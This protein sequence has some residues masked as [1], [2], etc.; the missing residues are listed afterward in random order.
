[1]IIDVSVLKFKM[2]TYTWRNLYS[3]QFAIFSCVFRELF[4]VC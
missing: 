3:L 2:Y 4:L 1:M